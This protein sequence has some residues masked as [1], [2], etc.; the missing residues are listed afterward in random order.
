MGVIKALTLAGVCAIGVSQMAHAAD[1]LPPAPQVEPPMLRGSMED[2]GFY[3]RADVGVG[4]NS[5]SKLR[6]TFPNATLA[7]LG[8]WDGPVSV[9][10]SALMGVG[11]GYQ[12]N[13]WFR[14]DLTGEYRSSSAY[15]SRVYYQSGASCAPG[16]ASGLVCGDAY[17]GSVRT[18][19]FLANGYADIG[20]WGGF[21]PYLGVG[22]GLASYGMHGV[23]DT[24]LFPA[25][26]YGAAP[27]NGG[28]NF[29][30]AL[31]AGVSYNLTQNLKFDMGYRFV[32]MGAFKTG[33]IQCNG[34]AAGGCNFE[35]QHYNMIA[36][37]FRFGLRWMLNP[38]VAYAPPL[39]TKY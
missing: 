29:A 31:M 13:S 22:V 38:V 30:W 19:L 24:A 5:A 35:T 36:N 1:L 2:S 39:V 37:D 18:G 10:D 3:L 15:N 8:A 21:T 27:S 20:S 23:T 17:N 9:E 32:D 4:A 25:G 33:V 12:F 28:T 6:S 11:V 14:A 7:S 34:G 16:N 26:G